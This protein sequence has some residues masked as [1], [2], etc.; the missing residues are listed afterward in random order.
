MLFPSLWMPSK[1]ILTSWGEGVF[2]DPENKFT[3]NELIW[4]LVLIMVRMILVKIQNFSTFG[5]MTSQNFLS[6]MEQVVAIR[7]LPNA[8]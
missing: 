7:Y 2:L 8:I 3:V 4:S 1:V 6:R 5:D